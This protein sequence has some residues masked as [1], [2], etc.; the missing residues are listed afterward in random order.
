MKD[1]R[2]YKIL[3]APDWAA[4]ETSGVIQTAL[5]EKDGY[6]HL[7][8]RDQVGD[9]LAL[10]YKE[11]K[12]VRLLEYR[13]VDLEQ[14]GALRWEP[15]RGGDLFPHLYGSLDLARAGQVWTLTLRAD[16]TPLLPWKGGG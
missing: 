16:G 6:V 15:S 11:A 12:G 14:M 13:H 7:S 1:Q 4:A 10:H 2:I 3:S 8:T 9:T 5:D